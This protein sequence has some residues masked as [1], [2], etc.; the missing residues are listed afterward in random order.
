M[1]WSNQGKT[2]LVL[3]PALWVSE[4]SCHVLL[5]P[6]RPW[7]KHLLGLQTLILIL[8]FLRHKPQTPHY[9]VDLSRIFCTML[10]HCYI[11][12]AADER[13]NNRSLNETE[14]ALLH[15]VVKGPGS[16]RLVALPSLGYCSCPQGHIAARGKGEE[17]SKHLSL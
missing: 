16:V 4:A 12:S 8:F 10:R 3:G 5:S 13:L 15:K 6:S 7:A 17:D 11:T 2:T 9:P 1:I 14:T